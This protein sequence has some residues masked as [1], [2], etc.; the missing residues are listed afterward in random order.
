MERRRVS[1]RR[2]ER[3][4]AQR[5]GYGGVLCMD[6][7]PPLQPEYK[8]GVKCMLS[9][10]EKVIIRARCLWVGRNNVISCGWSANLPGR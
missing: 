4:H 7:D 6:V 8:S 1:S 2:P 3:A 5:F 10:C 9:R